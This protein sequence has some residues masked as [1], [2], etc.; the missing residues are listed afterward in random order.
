MNVLDKLREMLNEA[1]IPYESYQEKWP[2]EWQPAWDKSEASRWPRNQ[3]I[4]GRRYGEWKFDA[5]YQYNSW[6]RE[7]NLV[8][9]YGELGADEGGNPRVMTAEEAFSIIKEDWDKTGGVKNG[10]TEPEV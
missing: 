9:T 1:E 3:I 7:K 6:G 4:Y 5:V 2:G 8:E 10:E